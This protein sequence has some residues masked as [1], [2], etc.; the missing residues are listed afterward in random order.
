M[1]CKSKC[2]FSS[3]GCIVWIQHQSNRLWRLRHEQWNTETISLWE[4]WNSQTGRKQDLW[5]TRLTDDGPIPTFHTPPSPRSAIICKCRR[6]YAPRIAIPSRAPSSGLAIPWEYVTTPWRLY[7]GCAT[8]EHLAPGDAAPMTSRTHPSLV[9]PNFLK[10]SDS[11]RH[12]T[13]HTW[14]IFQRNNLWRAVCASFFM[15][16][17]QKLTHTSF[18]SGATARL[19]SQKQ[20]GSLVHIAYNIGLFSL[21]VLCVLPVL[22]YKEPQEWLS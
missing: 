18:Y 4:F 16:K 2:V 21:N 13:K 8:C 6:G 3:E 1:F 22:S 15:N 17:I 7:L 10:S 12:N 9:S 14:I 19:E 20:V 5:S 11:D